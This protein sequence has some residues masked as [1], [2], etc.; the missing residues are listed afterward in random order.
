MVVRGHKHEQSKDGRDVIKLR[1]ELVLSPLSSARGVKA[2]LLCNT[3]N[4]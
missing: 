3:D 1:N 2:V 4:I